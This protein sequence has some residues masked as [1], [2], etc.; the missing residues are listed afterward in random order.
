M[1]EWLINT[2]FLRFFKCRFA[3]WPVA[4][5]RLPTSLVWWKVCIHSAASSTW[6]KKDSILM[7][8]DFFHVPTLFAA[9]IWPAGDWYIGS[10][11]KWSVWRT[12]RLWVVSFLVF[13]QVAW[14]REPLSAQQALVRPLPSVDVLVDLQVPELG[15]LFATDSAAVGSLSS[16]SSEVGL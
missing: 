10:S 14:V 5:T 3:V 4:T 13:L 1:S 6:L 2:W 16:V 15:E 11:C 9:E 7:W 8:L 12:L